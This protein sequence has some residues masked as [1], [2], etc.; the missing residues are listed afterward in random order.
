MATFGVGVWEAGGRRE[1]GGR[2]AGGRHLFS[3]AQ[4]NAVLPAAFAA[5]C[6]A[7]A[8][9]LKGGAGRRASETPQ[10]HLT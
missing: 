1:G 3:A 8:R 4:C 6:R 2:E 7:A 5:I 10:E 9:L